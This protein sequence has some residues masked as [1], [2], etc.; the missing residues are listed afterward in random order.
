MEKEFIEL[1]GYFQSRL[2]N[3]AAKGRIDMAN[4]EMEIRAVSKDLCLGCAEQK[5]EGLLP[6]VMHSCPLN[7]VTYRGGAGF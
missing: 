5:P 2:E 7:T 4:H 3:I 1:N 6:T